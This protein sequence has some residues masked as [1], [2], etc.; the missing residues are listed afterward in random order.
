VS[1]TFKLLTEDDL[2]IGQLTLP[3][4]VAQHVR[5]LGRVRVSIPDAVPLLPSPDGT[6][7]AGVRV[8][9]I[10]L[11]VSAPMRGIRLE[12]ATVEEIEALDGFWFT[13]S[14]RYLRELVQRAPAHVPW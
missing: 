7:P 1:S 2:M 10:W 3:E 11:A 8:F 9:S 5:A 12:G 4:P 14:A 6:L 13:P